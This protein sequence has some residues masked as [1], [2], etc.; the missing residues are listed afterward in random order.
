M[1]LRARQPKG[2][3][4]GGFL[5]LPTFTAVK[6]SLYCAERETGSE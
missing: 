6:L 3:L 5:R 4:G 1:K 2:Y